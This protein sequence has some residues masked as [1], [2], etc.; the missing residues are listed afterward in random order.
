MDNRCHR[1]G[2]LS[3][4]KKYCN[5]FG[6]QQENFLEKMKNSANNKKFCQKER[7]FTFKVLQ[8]VILLRNSKIKAR[9]IEQK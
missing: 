1:T 9:N 6:L 4:V 2:I 7:N 8:N 3:L 5:K